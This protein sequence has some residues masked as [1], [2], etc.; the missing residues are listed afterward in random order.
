[1]NLAQKKMSQWFKNPTC[2]SLIANADDSSNFASIAATMGLSDSVQC[3]MSFVS[4]L[5]SAQTP[6][7]ICV[8]GPLQYMFLVVE[9]EDAGGSFSY[10]PMQMTS[11][12][13]D[14]KCVAFADNPLGMISGENFTFSA[15]PTD[16]TN[17][18]HCL[19]FTIDD[20]M[21]PL[22]VCLSSD[23]AVVSQRKKHRMSMKQVELQG[24]Q[25]LNREGSMRALQAWLDKHNAD[26]AGSHGVSKLVWCE[27]VASSRSGNTNRAF[28]RCDLLDGMKRKPLPNASAAIEAMQSFTKS[29][30]YEDIRL[31]TNSYKLS[32]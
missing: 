13:V 32:D 6:I 27:E 19:A 15:I 25:I 28:F 12:V 9:T 18:D 11:E 7:A 2:F 17:V 16:T 31:R 1:M 14:V 21:H 4:M 22:A 29:D 5:T 26:L 10:F 23:A 20:N 8:S 3:K 24:G 30:F